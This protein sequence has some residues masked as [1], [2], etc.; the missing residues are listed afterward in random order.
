VKRGQAI[1][2][3]QSEPILLSSN[4]TSEPCDTDYWRIRVLIHVHDTFKREATP[5]V[6]IAA[7]N[8][9]ASLARAFLA[10]F[11]TDADMLAMVQHHDEPYALW[12]QVTTKGTFNHQRLTA[13][14]AA[15]S[16]WN[17]VLAF[18]I[19]DGCTE[20]KGRE[21]LRW[22]FE[23]VGGKVDSQFSSADRLY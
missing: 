9:H 7:L 8:G 16:D 21:P 19:V 10:D 2:K 15:I 3:E 22:F 20:G 17:L 13:L 12:R 6:P 14:V 11:C 23:R 5:G 4:A 18:T 1:R